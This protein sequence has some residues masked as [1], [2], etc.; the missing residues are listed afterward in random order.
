M[1]GDMLKK[2]VFLFILFSFFVAKCFA[3]P[4]NSI[5]LTNAVAHTSISSSDY[6]SNNNAI[7]SAYNNH[8]HIDITQLST[9]TNGV[10]AATTIGTTYGGTGLTSYTTGDLLYASASNTLSNLA[11]VATGNVLLSGG[12]STA[13]SWGKVDLASAVSGNLPVTNLNSGTSAS[14]TTFWRGDS[15]WSDSLSSVLDY[16]T[17]ASTSSA[18][19][20]AALKI[21]YGSVNIGSASSQGIINLPFSSAT[22][23]IIVATANRGGSDTNAVNAV[24]N[25][26]NSATIY[27]GGGN[28]NDV[29]WLA[30]GT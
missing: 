9:V 2:I 19:S 20:G 30:I 21:C 13:P 15:S 26:A 1:G 28:S 6:N 8:S 5:S 11:D 23:Y 29:F 14:A 3:A 24:R 7:S 16:G 12:V 25:S 17:S 18:K 27:N 4:S 10:W 22:S